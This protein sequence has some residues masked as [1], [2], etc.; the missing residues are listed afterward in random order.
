MNKKGL[1]ERKKQLQAEL[2][3]I[4]GEIAAIELLEK[5]YEAIATGYSGT[6]S[7]FFPTEEKALKK[8]EE[9]RGKTRFRNGLL[10]VVELVRHNADGTETLLKREVKDKLRWKCPQ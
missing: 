9:Y 1:V 7:T 2:D 5:P 3:R 6:F 8:Y 4:S 10:Y